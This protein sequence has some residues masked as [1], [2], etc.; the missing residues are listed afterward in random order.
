MYFTL[1]SKRKENPT[2][3]NTFTSQNDMINDPI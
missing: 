2:L 3:D 1:V